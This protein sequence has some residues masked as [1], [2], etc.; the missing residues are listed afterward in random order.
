MNLEFVV[1]RL[2]H[3]VFGAIWVGSAVFMAF[4]VVP[5]ARALGPAVAG[6]LLASLGKV[7]GPLLLGSGTITVVF[8]TVLALRIKW[9]NLDSWFDTG[10]GWAIAL[11][12]V[13][14]VTALAV[15]SRA[16]MLARQMSQMSQGMQGRPPTPEEMQ[17]M[18]AIAERLGRLVVQHH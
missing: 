8:G 13:M 9:N 3:I 7:V 17:Q 2:V 1:W 5:R 4:V 18:G 14:S 10:W 12:F 16:A 6:P 15:G 11:G